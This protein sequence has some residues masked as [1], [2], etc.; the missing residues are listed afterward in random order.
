MLRRLPSTVL[1]GLLRRQLSVA[2]LPA[3]AAALPHVPASR[4]ADARAWGVGPPLSALAASALFATQ[5]SAEAASPPPSAPPDPAPGLRGL[6]RLSDARG[7]ALY[8]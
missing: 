6:A 8:Q 7:V 2:L 5:A 4:K 3:A 1:S